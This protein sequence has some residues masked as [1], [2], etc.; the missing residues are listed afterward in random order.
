MNNEP[1]VYREMVKE[2]I[3]RNQKVKKE[4]FGD[5]PQDSCSLPRTKYL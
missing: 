4:T 1:Q 3:D 2:P 5:L